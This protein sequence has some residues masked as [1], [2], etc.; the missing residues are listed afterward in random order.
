MYGSEMS[1]WAR[2]IT[3]LNS[4]LLLRA[5]R[6]RVFQD[7]GLSCPPSVSF[8]LN[9]AHACKGQRG[10]SLKAP[11]LFDI[12]DSK[13]SGCAE[14][15]RATWSHSEPKKG[16]FTL[17]MAA[18]SSLRKSCLPAC[19]HGMRNMVLASS[20]HTSPGYFPLLTFKTT[21]KKR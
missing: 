3:S 2:S 7:A 18:S 12:M 1:S 16:F 6:S 4:G 14:F 21:H 17:K 19:F 20:S 9:S 8:P 15:F 13:S 5:Q 11:L 10:V